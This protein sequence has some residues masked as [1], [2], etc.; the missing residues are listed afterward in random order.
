MYMEE[1]HIIHD[2]TVIQDCMQ[3]N[4]IIHHHL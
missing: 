2:H 3:I 4:Q 1:I